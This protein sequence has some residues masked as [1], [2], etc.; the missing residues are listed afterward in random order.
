MSEIETLSEA[1]I[2]VLA[3]LRDASARRREPTAAH[4]D[5]HHTMFTVTDLVSDALALAR[6]DGE[7]SS[8][9]DLA[10]LDKAARGLAKR[11]LAARRTI[12]TRVY[13]GL[14][15]EGLALLDKIE[16]EAG[17]TDLAAAVHERDEATAALAE[18]ERRVREAQE[19]LRQARKASGARYPLEALL[20]A[21]R[22]HPLSRRGEVNA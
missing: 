22:R 11:G 2:I 3:A 16:A 6:W 1:A 20:E 15:T 7:A 21:R 4:P 18:A 12:Y 9:R 10:G 5:G 13:Y 8:Y 19:A 17:V 14:T